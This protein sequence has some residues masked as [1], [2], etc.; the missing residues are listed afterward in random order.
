MM[1]NDS[2]GARIAQIVQRAGA[3]T[4]VTPERIVRELGFIAF[5]RASQPY[6]PDGRMKANDGI[7][8]ATS[9]LL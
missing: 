7:G 2:I 3:A 8:A 4:D 5:Q 9:P 1:A 6:H